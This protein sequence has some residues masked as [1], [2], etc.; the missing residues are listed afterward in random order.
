[1][2]EDNIEGAIPIESSP[3]TFDPSSLI[4]GQRPFSEMTDDEMIRGIVQLR[5][6]RDPLHQGATRRA[7]RVPRNRD[8][9]QPKPKV[10]K[11][12][13]TMDASAANFLTSL[14]AEGDDDAE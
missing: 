13:K 9:K 3:T 14:F 4:L 8:V 11:A 5:D 1:V 12:S 7:L 2:T 6:V 10:S